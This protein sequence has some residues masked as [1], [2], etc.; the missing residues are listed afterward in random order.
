MIFSGAV[1]YYRCEACASEY[2]NVT[3]T[4]LLPMGTVVAVTAAP[5]ARVASRF[6]TYRWLSFAIGLAAAILSLC[7]I[8][9]LVEALTTS[10]V[11]RRVCPKCG[12]GLSKIGGGFY[13]GIVPNP[14]E[15]LIYLLT[16]ALGFAVFLV[17]RPSV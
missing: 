1:G 8:Y 13:D 16:V 2:T 4:S 6:I 15:L 10:K 3:P 9:A 5:W 14:W 12:A 7:L 11:R 17:T